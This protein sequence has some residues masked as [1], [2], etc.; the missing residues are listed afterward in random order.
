LNA[1]APIA[2]SGEE[3]PR[4]SVPRPQDIVQRNLEGISHGLSA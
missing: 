2:L 4:T 1:G 3:R